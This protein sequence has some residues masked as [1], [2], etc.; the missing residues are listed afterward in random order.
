MSQILFTLLLTPPWHTLALYLWFWLAP[1]TMI[2][3]EDAF[4]MT[5]TLGVASRPDTFILN[6]GA[7]AF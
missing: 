7:V 6:L 5:L 2:Y 4:G 3:F 1:N